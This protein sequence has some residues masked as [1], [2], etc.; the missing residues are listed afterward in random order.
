MDIGQIVRQGDV[1]LVR[2]TEEHPHGD[3]RTTTGVGVE[4]KK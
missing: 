1:Y 4:T 3:V 2:V